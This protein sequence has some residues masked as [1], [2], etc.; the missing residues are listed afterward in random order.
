MLRLSN[1]AIFVERPDTD[2]DVLLVQGYSG[3][4]DLVTRETARHLK[5]LRAGERFK[6]IAGNFD[7][8]CDI[9]SPGDESSIPEEMVNLLV[10]R[11]YLTELTPEEE[12]QLV[13]TIAN[14][15]HGMAQHEPPS[16]VLALTYDCNLRC[17]YCFQDALRADPANAPKLAVMTTDLVD[18]IFS[19]MPQ[20]HA[21]H[22]RQE[23]SPMAPP[24]ITLFGG[25]PLL[26]RHRP[27]VSHIIQRTRQLG[28]PS[29]AA[30][31]N[32]TELH[33]FKDLLGPDGIS[34]LQITLDGSPSEHD[35]RRIGPEGLPTFNIIA[36]NI[37]LALEQG[38]KV[39][40]RV[41]VDPTNLHSLPELADAITTRGW[42][43]RDDLSVYAT[44]VHE[45]PGSE[46]EACGFGT[47]KLS[48]Q[49]AELAAGQSN[50]RVFESPDSPLKRRIRAVLGEDRDP[51]LSFQPSFC[52]AHTRV[53]VFDAL[54]DLYACWERAGDG[55]SRIGRL[56][57][58]GE[59]MM[60]PPSLKVW[61]ERTV[62][63]NPV[64]NRCP[65][66]FYCGGGC[67]L[68]AEAKN[69]KLHSNFCDDFARRFRAIALEE[70]ETRQLREFVHTFEPASV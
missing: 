26:S 69:G 18:R 3:A 55:V 70:L 59:L 4:W 11:G 43:E 8:H 68:L 23:G 33:S 53:W 27:V 61:R 6:P 10:R 50:M 7:D 22:N 64:C 14:E 31:T 35:R 51:L 47:W 58:A 20:V 2:S 48:Q 5:R 54:G 52:G 36:D 60:N 32:G 42:S 9:D 44:P 66:A 19:A 16:I 65:Y 49:L 25:E 13:T 37:D 40:I 12:Q 41:N 63:S 57:E 46:H 1:Y 39:K 28:P 62:A 56:S 21:L 30:I 45:S 34:F 24:R 38:A 67:A 15:L 29:I 17:A